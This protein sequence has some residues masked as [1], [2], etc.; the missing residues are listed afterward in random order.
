MRLR[1]LA[2]VGLVTKDL[3]AWAS[4]GDEVLGLPCE[5]V[6]EDRLLLR[7]DERTY[8]FDVRR[9]A[10]DGLSWL[11]WEV[12]T[13]ADLLDVE[14]H[15]TAAGVAVHRA[16]EQ[17]RA[18]RGVA[19][20]LWLLDPDG[21]RHEFSHGQEA[22]FRTLRL[23]R[24]LS[25]YRTGEFGMGHAVIGVARYAETLDFLVGTLGFRISDTF[26]NVIA[27]LH[28][29]SR[30]HSIALVESDEPGLRHIMLETT[31][32][33]DVGAT[34]DVCLRRG[35]VTRTLGRH[36]NDR[37]VSFYLTTPSGWEIEYG[38]DGLAVDQ[39]DWSERQ[40]VG[41]TSLWGHQHVVGNEITLS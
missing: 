3:S 30:H 2:Y 33:D 7:M 35:I 8:R 10:T 39:A 17:E 20:L 40:L 5:R 9:G 28:C 12:A 32:L 34:I 16:T 18:D 21:V 27:F 24:A 37:A 15:L 36:S 6:G 25:G 14:A 38:W 4:F 22:D 31:S 1:S 29:N 11:G 23:T 41:P 19:G 13:A 26:D